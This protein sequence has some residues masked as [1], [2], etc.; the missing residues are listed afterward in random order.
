MDG[1]PPNYVGDNYC[2]DLTNNE[3]CEWDGGDCCGSNVNTLACE[4]CECLDPTFN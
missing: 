2:D 3:Q 1:C 4:I